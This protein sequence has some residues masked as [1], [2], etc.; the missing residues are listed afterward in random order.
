MHLFYL[1][2]FSPKISDRP[3]SGYVA[4]AEFKR[5]L[6]VINPSFITSLVARTF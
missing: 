2:L 4:L 1:Y 3:L 5:N 6:K